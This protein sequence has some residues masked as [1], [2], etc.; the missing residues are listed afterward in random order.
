MTCIYFNNFFS[1]IEIS[2]AKI[3]QS[4]TLTNRIKNFV[5][6]K[7]EKLKKIEVWREFRETE[8]GREETRGQKRG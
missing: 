5:K 7:I 8:R 2:F 6:L 3:L 4:A 1:S